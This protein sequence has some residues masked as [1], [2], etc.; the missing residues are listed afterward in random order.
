MR[1][2]LLLSP[3]SKTIHKRISLL[4]PFLPTI[5]SRGYQPDKRREQPKKFKGIVKSYSEFSGSGVVQLS[6]KKVYVPRSIVGET[7]LYSVRNERQDYFK[8]YELLLFFFN[9][10]V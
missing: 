7:I 10:I 4:S 6:G 2:D 8:G 5:F 3:F 1:V 9:R